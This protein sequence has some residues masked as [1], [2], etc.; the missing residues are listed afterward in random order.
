[1]IDAGYNNGTVYSH[2]GEKIYMNQNFLSNNQIKLYD[3]K[4]NKPYVYANY[5]NMNYSIVS[6]IRTFP[7]NLEYEAEFCYKFVE[8]S[9]IWDKKN[10]FYSSLNGYSSQTIWYLCF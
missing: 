4:N 8:G 2:T 10:L 5:N 3:S 9:E 7:V 1:M 6:E